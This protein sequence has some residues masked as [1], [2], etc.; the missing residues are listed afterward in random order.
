LSAL[1]SILEKN[2]LG[3]WRK[4]YYTRRKYNKQPDAQQPQPL[5][6]ILNC[7]SL[8]DILQEDA[9]AFHYTGLVEKTA[10]IKK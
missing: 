8:P 2:T 4:V 7:F 1:N 5:P 9:E 6:T 10:T 3:N